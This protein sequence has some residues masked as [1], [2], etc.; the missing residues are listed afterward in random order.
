[1]ARL[2]LQADPTFKAKVPIPIPGGAPHPVEMEFRHRTRKELDDLLDRHKKSALDVDF[3]L[4]VVIGWDLEDKFE[5]KNVA[6]L[7]DQYGGAARAIS[8]TY[9]RELLG[10]RLGN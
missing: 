7:L 10:L 4:A 5:R 1:M 6:T 8:E 2:K 9:T 3:V